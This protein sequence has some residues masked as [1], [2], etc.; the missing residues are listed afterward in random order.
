MKNLFKN[1]MLVAVAAM[2]FTACT[3]T[4]EEVNAVVEKTVLKFVAGFDEETRS[5]FV[6][7]V[8]EG[9]KTLYKSA[10][11]GGEYL[12]VCA[13]GAFS[14]AQEVK[15]EDAEGHFTVVFEGT[16]PT[17]I[18]VYSPASAWISEGYPTVPAVQTPRA[19]SVDPAA[20]LLYA[21]NQPVE[22]GVVTMSHKLAYG[23]M[24]VKDV[25]FAIDHVVV[26]IKGTYYGYDCDMSY[27][28]NAT[29]V[30]NNEF[31]FAVEYAVAVSSLTVTAYG[32]GDEVVTKTVDMAGKEKP[33]AF[34]VGTVST[35]S[36]S[37]LEEAKET[38]D[39]TSAY[40]YEG[41]VESNDV[42]Y[43][44]VA[45]DNR[46]LRIDFVGVIDN[47]TIP[48]GTYTFS[49]SYGMYPS[50]SYYY[51][52][53]D[54]GWSATKLK[55]GQAV[56][57][58]DDGQY[59]IVFTN[60]AD[61]NGNV[62]VE[63]FTF[64]GELPG[65]AIPDPRAKLAT[66]EVSYTNEGMVVTLTWNAIEGVEYYSVECDSEAIEN[67][68]TT[69]TTATIT[70]PAYGA[71]G[72]SVAAKVADNNEKYKS[73]DAATVKVVV[74]DPNTW[75]DYEITS[76][77][78]SDNFVTMTDAN[79]NRVTFFMN[80]ADRIGNGIK[81]G[82]YS[83]IYSETPGV[84][85]FA[86]Y[87][88]AYDGVYKWSY[89]IG[90]GSMSVEEQNGQYKI[91]ITVDGIRFGY[92][93][94]EAL[95]APVTGPVIIPSTEALEFIQKGG[96]KTVDLVVANLTEDVTATSTNEHF[97]A[98][99]SGNVLTV[100]A[101]ENTVEAVQEATITLSANGV[102]ATITVSQ[103]AY[104]PNAA[105]EDGTEANPYIFKSA[106]YGNWVWTFTDSSN[107]DRVLMDCSSPQVV[108]WFN[109]NGY[110]VWIRMTKLLY[111]S[112]SSI[113]GYKGNDYVNSA[114]WNNSYIKGVKSGDVYTLTF[115]MS[116]DGTTYTYYQYVGTF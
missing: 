50:W 96:E 110:D 18:D 33:L 57:S 14:S 59:K 114:F 21:K 30:D 71:Y 38:Y 77:A 111:G 25:D 39:S 47:N 58:V 65:L 74:K 82:D 115:K 95:G 78:V 76:V 91:L 99:V 9:E 98:T 97:T 11:D 48:V 68:T 12:K 64:K 49:T 52:D 83:Y 37:G 27:T 80:A 100:V 62:V 108:G 75:A 90:S 112:G 20:H 42:S 5:G 92:I 103:E 6:G 93:G 22:S 16:A 3:E 8:T 29:Y 104:N 89:Q 4:N 10:W 24:T 46:G 105:V 26:D 84:G 43:M 34:N 63:K 44:F 23:K 101:P 88:V 28:I 86:V 113:Y 106:S 13:N 51:P 73:S 1:L 45:D 36:V 19:N 32:A 66:P 61:A 79:D 54:N 7:S 109:D 40:I 41:A 107:G 85:Q 2:A 70:L 87:V 102:N 72:F 17:S 31:W 35:F 55:Y 60:L 53:V 15:L 94:T 69:E 116:V 56:V 67:F 81:L